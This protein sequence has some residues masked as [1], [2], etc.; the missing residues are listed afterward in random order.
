M[1]IKRQLKSSRP[2]PFEVVGRG[3]G[4]AYE[5]LGRALN[6]AQRLAEA[7]K[8]AGHFTVTEYGDPIYR[9]SKEEDGAV[10]TQPV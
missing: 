4:R 3:E 2:T 6:V 9:V 10:I 5:T 7:L 8:D 1:K